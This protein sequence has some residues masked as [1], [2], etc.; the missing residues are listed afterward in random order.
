MKKIGTLSLSLVIAASITGCASTSDSSSN[1]VAVYP[2]LRVMSDKTYIWDDSISEA[3]NVARMAQ[4]AGVGVGMQDFADGTKANTGRVGTGEQIFDSALGMA[5]MGAFGVISMN[6]LNSDVNDMLDWHPSFVF[7][8]P[9][10]EISVSG[11]YDLKKTQLYVGNKIKTAL[12]SSLTDMTWYGAYTLR[13]GG[14]EQ[15]S[16]FAINTARCHDSLKTH[17]IDEKKAPIKTTGISKDFF[18]ESHDLTEFC[19]I[20]LKLKVSG[21]IEKSGIKQAIVVGEVV[22][23][24]YFMDTV[25][26]KLDGYMLF[27]E[28]FK[29][30]TLDSKAGKRLGYPYA[31]AMKNGN[32]LKFQSK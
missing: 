22:E 8:V 7:V 10:E 26:G 13:F 19:S 12:E 32:E 23:G 6:V 18:F 4:P 5:G 14:E 9:T 28:S 17:Y 27:P 25:K 29:V 24:H 2:E 30:V 21:F 3:L 1:Q 20:S 11:K 16:T 31:Y 15:N